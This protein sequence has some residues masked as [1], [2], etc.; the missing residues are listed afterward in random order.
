[1]A[2]T[3]QAVKNDEKRGYSI[4]LVPK[5]DAVFVRLYNVIKAIGKQYS[6]P[7]FEPHITLIGSLLGSEQEVMEKTASLAGRI[8]PYTAT[9]G[10]VDQFDEYFKALIVRMQKT[11][12]VM[13]SNRMAREVFVKQGST[14]YMPHLSLM[15]ADLPKETKDKIIKDYELEAVVKKLKPFTIGELSLHYTTGKAGEWHKVRDFKLRK[16]KLKSTV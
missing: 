2:E 4:W 7:M 1:M 12:E 8:K 13:E 15:Y 9:F 3:K 16:E 11:P 14:G 5:D 6:T 10:N